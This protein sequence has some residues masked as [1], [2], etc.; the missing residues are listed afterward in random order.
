MRVPFYIMATLAL[1]CLSGLLLV[2]AASDLH[3]IV[4]NHIVWCLYGIGGLAFLWGGYG[5]AVLR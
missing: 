3:G 1:V 2:L 5:L 4:H